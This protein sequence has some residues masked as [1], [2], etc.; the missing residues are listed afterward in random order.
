MKLKERYFIKIV[1]PRGERV[2]RFEVTR[3]RI[4]GAAGLLAVI[5]SASVG[6]HFWRLHQAGAQLESLRILTAQQHAQLST[7]DKQ[8]DALRLQ[9]QKVQTQ[10]QQIQQAIGIHPKRPVASRLQ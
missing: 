9:L 2:H 4:V 7:I 10:N 3:R 5:L 6:F 1:P 8:T